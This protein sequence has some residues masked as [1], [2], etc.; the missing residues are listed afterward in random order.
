VR[1][2]VLAAAVLTAAALLG[3]VAGCAGKEPNIDLNGWKLTLPEAND[4]GRAKEVKPAEV[5]EPWM[6]VTEDG[7]LEF[8]APTSGGATTPNSTHPRS[9]LISLTEWPAGQEAHILRTSVTVKQV[10]RDGNGIIVGQIHGA[11]AIRSVAF[12]MLRWKHDALL[13]DVKTIQK[14]TDRIVYQLLGG[15]PLNSRFDFTI[16]DRGNGEMVLT[17]AHQG[18]RGEIRTRIPAVFAGQPVRFQAGDYQ[19]ADRPEGEGDGGRIVVHQLAEAVE[20][21]GGPPGPPSPGVRIS[22]NPAE[23]E[24]GWPPRIRPQPAA[25]TLGPGPQPAPRP[26][27]QPAPQSVPR[28]GPQPAPQSAPHPVPQSAPR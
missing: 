25:Q 23:L 1:R 9:E 15:I 18:R 27:R 6:T 17:A 13:L 19:Q 5:T 11:A 8:W 24:P 22:V 7:S 12:V 28:P 21:P 4:K 14:G 16:A 26:G 2:A 10:P 3:G 20:Q